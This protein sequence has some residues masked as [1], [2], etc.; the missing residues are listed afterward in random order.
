MS[1]DI[2]QNGNTGTLILVSMVFVIMVVVIV[3]MA[4]CT[5]K[6]YKVE[7]D[8]FLFTGGKHSYRAGAE[9]ELHFEM[10]ATDTDYS[11]YLNDDTVKLNVEGTGH[12]YIIRFTMPEHDVKL[13]FDC[14]NSMEYVPE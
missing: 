1:E 3:I 2:I 14:K 10:V 5:A 7:Y 11:F 8:E 4:G 13:D 9:V 12:G 6:K